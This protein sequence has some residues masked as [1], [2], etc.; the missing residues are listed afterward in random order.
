MN[1]SPDMVSFVSRLRLYAALSFDTAHRIGAERS[2]AVDKPD[3]PILVTIDGRPYIPGSSFKGAWR[4]YTEA[5]LRTLQAQADV[6]VKNLACLSVNKPYDYKN[7]PPPL[8]RC[9]SQQDVADLKAALADK[10]AQ[11]DERLRQQS[12]WVCR[13][14]GSGWLAAKLLV[15][16]I[17][18]QPDTFFRTEIRDGVA[19]D[20]DSA[21][22]R[23]GMLY[24]FEAAP[25]GL[26]FDVEIVIENAS[27]AELGLVWLGLEAF[28]RGDIL[29]GGAKSRGLGWCSLRPDYEQSRY[30]QSDN[31]LAYLFQESDAFA[32][33]DQKVKAW[34]DAFR[35][36]LMG[37]PPSA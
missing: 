2:L 27:P 25:P 26:K 37:T 19:I 15:K 7:D 31:L 18:V 10:P 29:L 23:D 6:K 22:A 21:R 11:L 20:R 34:R 5:V 8:G 35:A 3:L 24:Q 28:K 30:V 13:V 12:C 14:F 16:D 33:T 1:A 9:L 17:M 32:L 36:V 4:S